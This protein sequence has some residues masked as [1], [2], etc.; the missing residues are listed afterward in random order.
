MFVVAAV[1][2]EWPWWEYAFLSDQSAVSWLSNAL[3]MADAAVALTLT[4]SRSMPTAWG[5][6]LAAALATLSV[7][8]QFRKTA[9]FVCPVTA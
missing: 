5:A 8:E 6:I 3:L 9:S 1:A 7:D 4:L 2:A